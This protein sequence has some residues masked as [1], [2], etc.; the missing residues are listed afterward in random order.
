MPFAPVYRSVFTPRSVR[1]AAKHIANL[2]PDFQTA[3]GFPAS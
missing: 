1:P 2:A 3:T